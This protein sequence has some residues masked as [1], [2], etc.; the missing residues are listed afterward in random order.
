MAVG[1]RDEEKPAPT[2]VQLGLL[3]D[4]SLYR[5]ALGDEPR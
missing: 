1:L 3:V 4:G 2:R 5:G